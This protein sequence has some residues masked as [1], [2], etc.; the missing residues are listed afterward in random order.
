[1]KEAERNLIYLEDSVRIGRRATE[2]EGESCLE[3]ELCK[4]FKS[5][6]PQ[7]RCLAHLL[8]SVYGILDYMEN[9]E[10]LEHNSELKLQ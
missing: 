6:L 2:E 10:H 3:C 4:V 7:S 5:G 1:M 9:E 8:S